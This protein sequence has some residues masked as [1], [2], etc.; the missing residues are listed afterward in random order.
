MVTHLPFSSSSIII[1]ISSSNNT[2]NNHNN[3][4]TNKQ[5]NQP[6][7]KQK[8][9]AQFMTTALALN[10]TDQRFYPRR[11][12]IARGW[13]QRLHSTKMNFSLLASYINL[14]AFSEWFFVN[15]YYH[16]LDTFEAKKESVPGPIQ[17]ARDRTDCRKIPKFN[18]VL[19]LNYT[20][21]ASEKVLSCAVPINQKNKV[22]SL[23]RLGFTTGC[24]VI[25]CVP[26]WV[27]E[28]ESQKRRSRGTYT[29][30]DKKSMTHLISFVTQTV[31]LLP[32]AVTA[33]GFFRNVEYPVILSDFEL[34][35]YFVFFCF[36]F[37]ILRLVLQLQL[38]L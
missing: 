14:D 10:E 15:T 27:S 20:I 30:S 34:Q 29:C 17:L 26:T 4:K 2:N 12:K 37:A 11:D 23:V 19:D 35:R 25:L 3:N 31:G 13:A 5:P 38:Q 16:S 8:G 22:S 9:M 28:T 1:I 21:T 33:I 6:T 24:N 7:T 36:F 32:Q 18:C